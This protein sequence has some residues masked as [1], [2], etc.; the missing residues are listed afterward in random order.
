M[1]REAQGVLADVAGAI[2]IT[3]FSEGTFQRG[4]ADSNWSSSAPVNREGCQIARRPRLASHPAQRER[5]LA[6]LPE[7]RTVAGEFQVDGFRP[8][9]P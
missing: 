4:A 6:V 1:R 2:G 7:H 3:M 5:P 9:H 8:A